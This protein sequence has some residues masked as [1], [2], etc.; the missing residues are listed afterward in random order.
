M[1]L[2]ISQLERVAAFSEARIHN[3]SNLPVGLSD[4]QKPVDQNIMDE[5]GK[6]TWSD[7]GSLKYWSG[8][9]VKP[10]MD[11]AMLNLKDQLEACA[12]ASGE[13]ARS[14]VEVVLSPEM[15]CREVYEQTK[16]LIKS[17]W[18]QMQLIRQSVAD[19]LDQLDSLRGL[20]DESEHTE[21][22]LNYFKDKL[23]KSF[24][25]KLQ[26]ATDKMLFRRK[27]LE[28]S[29]EHRQRGASD[30]HDTP[31][32]LTNRLLN[33]LID[34]SAEPID[35]EMMPN[36]KEGKDRHEEYAKFLIKSSLTMCDRGFRGNRLRAYA[37]VAAE[38]LETTVQNCG[39]SRLGKMALITELKQTFT[40]DIKAR[41]KNLSEENKALDP[42]LN[43]LEALERITAGYS[44]ST[45]ELTSAETSLTHALLDDPEQYIG[46]SPQSSLSSHQLHSIEQF[47][48]QLDSLPDSEKELAVYSLNRNLLSEV[49]QLPTNRQGAVYET[50]ARNSQLLSLGRPK[51]E[52]VTPEAAAVQLL[53]GHISM[54]CQLHHVS[55]MHGDHW[56]RLLVDS[57]AR[58][59]PAQKQAEQR[60]IAIELE[61]YVFEHQYEYP[62]LVHNW[63]FI[64]HQLNIP[65]HAKEETD[66]VQAKPLVKPAPPLTR[67]DTELAFTLWQQISKDISR[68]S[69][70][71]VDSTIAGWGDLLED[72]KKRF[73]KDQHQE[74]HDNMWM[75]INFELDNHAQY[76]VFNEY[77]NRIEALFFPEKAI[78]ISSNVPV[79]PKLPREMTEFTEDF[80]ET[81]HLGFAED[82]FMQIRRELILN[83]DRAADE[84][85]DWHKHIHSY[86]KHFPPMLRPQISELIAGNV[87]MLLRK[88]LTDHSH[89]QNFM[90][91]VESVFLQAGAEL[92]QPAQV[93]LPEAAKPVEKAQATVAPVEP[94]EWPAIHGPNLIRQQRILIATPDHYYVGMD[95]YGNLVYS[96]LSTPAFAANINRLKRS[97]DSYLYNVIIPAAGTSWSP[98]D[99]LQVF[100]PQAPDD[101]KVGALK[102]S[103]SRIQANAHTLRVLN[104]EPP[105]LDEQQRFNH[106]RNKVMVIGCGP[107]RREHEH[108]HPHAT[109]FTADLTPEALADL[110]GDINSTI[111]QLPNTGNF[112]A[113]YFEHIDSTVFRDPVV[114][115]ALLK[116]CYR[117]LQPGGLLIISTGAAGLYTRED[118]DIREQVVQHI[119]GAGFD[120]F[121]YTTHEGTLTAFGTIEHNAELQ[122]QLPAIYD[123]AP[124]IGDT[125]P[126]N[127]FD[128]LD[129]GFDILAVKPGR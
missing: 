20:G 120:E 114:A 84:A 87:M 37:T 35:L 4:Q 61:R 12:T 79:T 77:R 124:V 85:S 106:C 16:K 111:H 105:T 10:T 13:F 81:I 121:K 118:F 19:F 27:L 52:P 68:M 80:D 63:D 112:S 82:L 96:E 129:I 78:D 108:V 123:S 74:I 64:R 14:K 58:T 72:L 62:E 126:R 113:I 11:T 48:Q 125:I 3:T 110:T 47:Q 26:N 109:T 50:V 100:L 1:P 86:I 33:G 119:S 46:A 49:D 38:K 107:S 17:D 127:R 90:P 69:F 21:N 116:K 95:P 83:P 8:W 34:L 71:P 73:P 41:N 70:S 53:L 117:L 99:Q 30:V 115:N 89:I 94:L 67:N 92:F 43:M 54:D 22:T 2:S 128:M 7:W 18:G 56:R 55:A 24:E 28:L 29:K 45:D 101:C 65:A 32:K 23:L 15:N 25:A 122:Q 98:E 31:F 103:L 88:E 93:N 42:L 104:T 91:L 5:A 97:M 6:T 36:Q 40:H 102:H 44:D 39:Q 76:P 60:R 57:T 66:Q 9:T 51:A 75:C 59:P